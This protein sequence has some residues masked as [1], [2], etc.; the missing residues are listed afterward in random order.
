M[1][2]VIDTIQT[3]TLI[4]LFTSKGELVAMTRRSFERKHS[5][6]LLVTLEDL[7]AKEQIKKESISKII[8][9]TGPGS[10]TGSRVGVATANALGF[11]L[12]IL[13]IPISLFDISKI[14]V[15]GF[16]GLIVI[17][18]YRDH[19][20]VHDTQSLTEKM[21][22]SGVLE[23]TKRE[24]RVVNKESARNHSFNF[25]HSDLKYQGRD[26]VRCWVS[27]VIDK[28]GSLE[29]VPLYFKSPKIT[30]PKR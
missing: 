16:S 14:L 19:F 30:R 4:A 8:C 12:G 25:V 21:V 24:I 26:A 29:I 7:L 11:G 10:Y 6:K 9:V 2:C 27:K 20:L 17:P 28:K 1:V 23:K 3:T 18:S 5:E 15:P 22:S 13:I